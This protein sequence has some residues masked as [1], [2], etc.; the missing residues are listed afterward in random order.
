[1]VSYVVLVLQNRC[2]MLSS[3]AHL[4]LLILQNYTE[5]KDIQKHYCLKDKFNEASDDWCFSTPSKVHLSFYLL[6]KTME[7]TS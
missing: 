5:V 4:D 2:V 1:M 6:N 3:K 7:S